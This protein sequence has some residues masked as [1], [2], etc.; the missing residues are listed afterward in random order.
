LAAKLIERHQLYGKR[1]IEIGSGD[2]QFLTTL[3]ERGDNTGLGFDP[4]YSRTSPDTLAGGRGKIIREH[5]SERHAEH[6]A[7]LIIAR[8]VLEHIPD[9]IDFLARLRRVVGTRRQTALFFEVP[10]IL[11]TL[12]DVLPWDLIYEHC[13][14]FSPGTLARTFVTAGF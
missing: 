12:I 14:S 2:G 7:D 1:I 13:S 3:C 10:S 11:P 6:H 5:H 4:S 9:P 8:H